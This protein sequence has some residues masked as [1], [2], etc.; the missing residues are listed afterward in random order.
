[1]KFSTVAVAPSSLMLGMLQPALAAPVEDDTNIPTMRI[2]QVDAD[3][4]ELVARGRPKMPGCRDSEAY[5][6][7]VATALLGCFSGPANSGNQACQ[8]RVGKSCR[9]YHFV[10]HP[11]L[12]ISRGLTICLRDHRQPIL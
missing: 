3:A 12:Y 11:F 8:G 6:L 9:K 1:M 2:R 10:I 5:Y 7:C 4:V